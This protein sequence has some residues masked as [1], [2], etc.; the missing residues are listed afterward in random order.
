MA[1][2]IE[3][4]DTQLED[5]SPIEKIV[6]DNRDIFKNFKRNSFP[7][8]IYQDYD[9]INNTEEVAVSQNDYLTDILTN[10]PE[11]F[12][13]PSEYYALNTSISE[14]TPNIENAF[15]SQIDEQQTWF[16]LDTIKNWCAYVN[17][18]NTLALMC[19]NG[20]DGWD[21]V[22]NIVALANDVNSMMLKYLYSPIFFTTGIAFPNNNYIGNYV[23][24]RYTNGAIAMIY[25]QTIVLNEDTKIITYNDKFQNLHDTKIYQ[26]G[27]RNEIANTDIGLSSSSTTL[28]NE[29]I[30][31]DEKRPAVFAVPTQYCPVLFKQSNGHIAISIIYHLECNGYGSTAETNPMQ[32]I[33][34]QEANNR[35]RNIFGDGSDKTI[36]KD[37]KH[38]F[39]NDATEEIATSIY[40]NSDEAIYGVPSLT[41]NVAT[42]EVN[43]IEIFA[44]RPTP[45][46]NNK[47]GDDFA[48]R[49]D[50]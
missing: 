16:W 10:N 11:Q 14:S 34:A 37:W 8:E 30:K 31:I 32:Q 39:N 4:V 40:S 3:P 43:K 17:E 23:P 41:L 1:D 24:I 9:E 19:W 33:S 47:Y 27:E 42:K 12:K 5:I 44:N 22:Q 45:G 46:S 21:R 49:W 25:Y 18:N 2:Y 20:I 48:E 36:L 6:G 50:R 15:S 28:S 7:N 13:T 35:C 38:Y 29:P 26:N